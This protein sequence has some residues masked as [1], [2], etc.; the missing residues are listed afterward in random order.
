MISNL[1][2]QLPLK[3]RVALADAIFLD[4]EPK[5]VAQ[6]RSEIRKKRQDGLRALA[7]ISLAAFPAILGA[8]VWDGND[9]GVARA[10]ASAAVYFAISFAV[11]SAGMVLG[12][13]EPMLRRKAPTKRFVIGPDDAGDYEDQSAEHHQ[14]EWVEENAHTGIVQALAWRATALL[15]W[16]ALI[17]S[18]FLFAT[19]LLVGGVGIGSAAAS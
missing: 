7:A 1:L 8:S 6:E 12:W 10:L 15:L 3:R 17:G 18:G 19:A 14:L 2:A 4:V 13:F 16:V 5:T 11:A 9:S